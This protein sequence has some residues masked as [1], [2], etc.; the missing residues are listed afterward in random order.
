MQNKL[1][2][3]KRVALHFKIATYCQIPKI[4]TFGDIN[5]GNLRDKAGITVPGILNFK[6]KG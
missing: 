4:S 3:K 5:L 2:I 1:S 6:D